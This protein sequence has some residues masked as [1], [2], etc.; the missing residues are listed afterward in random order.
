MKKNIK[1]KNKIALITG[2]A[3][4]IGYHM[5]L[6]LLNLGWSVVGVDNFNPYYDVN[7]KKK[8]HKLL[9]NNK[10]FVEFIGDINKFYF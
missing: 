7:L 1:N 9:L 4:F 3:G 6:H 10:N 2:S 5:S 8:R